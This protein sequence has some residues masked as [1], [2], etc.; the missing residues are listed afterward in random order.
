MLTNSNT[1]Q[2]IIH[3]GSHQ[4]GGSCVELNSPQAKIII[5]CGLP[6][7]FDDKDPKTQQK[8][9]EEA[10]KWLQ[11]CDAIFLSHYHG[12]HYGLLNEAPIGTKVFTSSETAL[13]M[14]LSGIFG[15]D[16]TKRLDIQ[17]FE[18]E[19]P[20]S[21]KDFTVT[22]FIVDH[23]AFGA[24]SFLF[25]W[26]DL[27]ILYSGDIR[28]HGRKGV[29]YKNLP[30]HVDYLFLEGTN[31]G[32]TVR[33]KTEKTVENNFVKRFSS[34]SD[35]LHMVWC[36]SQNIDRIVSLYRACVKTN[37]FFCVDSYT[38]YVLEIV[39]SL[40][41][42]IPTAKTHPNLLIYYPRHL[43]TFLNKKD[44]NIIYRPFQIDKK[45][46][47]SNLRKNPSKYVMIFRP[48]LLQD[49]KKYLDGYKICLTNSIWAK[50]WEQDKTEINN[51]KEWLD[52]APELRK[53]LPDIHTS[54]HADI[55]SLQK[56]VQHIQP[57]RIIP[58]H[59]EIP[60]KYKDIFANYTIINA[61]DE[62]PLELPII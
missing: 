51:L 23:S 15:E 10:R 29:L 8:I 24:C 33:Q 18:S 1:P 60:E 30:Q 9:R 37:R 5:D 28:I 38:A 52:E 19:N 16:L 59:T 34:N 2:F 57:K 11:N 45:L 41:S 42:T 25:E 49:L 21:C 50:Y 31:M 32:Y 56:I 44:K 6:L 36:S 4:I 55:T 7:D 58:I 47:I 13:L 62:T 43:T 53:K 20:V 48:K 46:K 40:R 14:K 22:Q 54:G 3:R 39:H 17:T 61:T 12:D 35:S 27:K 26:K